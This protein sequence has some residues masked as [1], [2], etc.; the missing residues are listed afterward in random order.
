[1]VSPPPMHHGGMG[2]RAASA[3]ALPGHHAYVTPQGH[4]VASSSPL[5]ARLGSSDVNTPPPPVVQQHAYHGRAHSPVRYKEAF[6]PPLSPNSPL[7]PRSPRSPK[8]RSNGGFAVLDVKS[9]QPEPSTSGPPRRMPQPL[10]RDA[11]AVPK[12]GPPTRPVTVIQMQQIQVPAKHHT[13]QPPPCPPAVQSCS[14][15]SGELPPGL[16]HADIKTKIEHFLLQKERTHLKNAVLRLFGQVAGRGAG[17]DALGLARFSTSLVQELRIPADIFTDVSL[18][19]VRFDFDGNGILDMNEVYK[20]VKFHFWEYW[21]KL[22]GPAAHSPVPVKTIDAAGYRVIRDLGQGS[23]GVVRLCK[24]KKDK[25]WC[26]KC[27]NKTLML[28]GGIEELHEEYEAM[29]LLGCERLAKTVEVFQDADFFY[30]VNEPYYG[31]DFKGLVDRA[32]QSGVR[33]S[34]DWW[35]TI[36]KQ[37]LQALA[38]MHQQAMIHCDIKEPNIMLKTKNYNAPEVVLVDFGICKAMGA[39]DDECTISGT[40]GY[41]PP[42]TINLGKW[43]PRGDLFSLGVV[44]FQMVSG[45]DLFTVGCRTFEDIFQR[46]VE[47]QPPYQYL[48]PRWPLFTNLVSK[49]LQKQCQLRPPAP[50]ALKDEWFAAGKPKAETDSAGTDSLPLQ[51]MHP[52]ATMGFKRR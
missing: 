46:T 52:L 1:V 15:T 49:L 40:P 35:R 10:R 20:L 38:F 19:Y 45:K 39:E 16:L 33:V 48:E 13:R 41:I 42:E 28:R 31:G 17:L 23:Q 30:M 24:D 37:C 12:G 50:R 3:Q 44:M 2:A 32:F 26:V 11:N 36:F 4:R 43:F 47:M 14:S 25:E 6:S 22:E 27:Y 9:H 34:E 5:R 51:S 18:D 21:K 29:Q 8:R 7:S